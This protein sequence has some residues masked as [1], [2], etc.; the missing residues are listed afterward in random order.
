MVVAD[1]VEVEGAE[2]GGVGP[3]WGLLTKQRHLS[4]GVE[5]IIHLREGEG[6]ERGKERG[7]R[8]GGEEGGTIMHGE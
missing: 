1:P 6:N 8:V 3:D 7:R 2:E 4:L 5:K